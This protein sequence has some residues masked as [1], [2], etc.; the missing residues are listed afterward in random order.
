VLMSGLDYERAVLS[1][2][3]VGIMQ[4]ALDIVVPYIHDRKQFGQSIGEFQLMQGKIADMYA[5]LNACRA[6]VYAVG[7]ALDRG[8]D[9]RKDA[10][11]VI[12]QSY[13]DAGTPAVDD[14]PELEP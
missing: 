2:G 8:Q 7:A 10:A 1:G 13:L 5:D 6:Y 9:S 14:P 4:A 3:P 12:L 11:A